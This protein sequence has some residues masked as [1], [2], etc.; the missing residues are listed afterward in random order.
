MEFSFKQVQSSKLVQ[1]ILYVLPFN[2]WM[3]PSLKYVNPLLIGFWPDDVL[4]DFIYSSTKVNVSSGMISIS[5]YSEIVIIVR[6]T[7]K[8]LAH[9]ASFWISD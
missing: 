7:D 8:M 2:S 4:Q 3:Y 5:L 6:D 9:L 1:S